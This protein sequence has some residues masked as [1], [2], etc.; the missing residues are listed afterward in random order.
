MFLEL[1][2]FKLYCPQ[3]IVVFKSGAIFFPNIT[4][5]LVLRTFKDT[6]IVPI[7]EREKLNR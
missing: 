5:L 6:P 7:K 4:F 2:T 3:A 1:E